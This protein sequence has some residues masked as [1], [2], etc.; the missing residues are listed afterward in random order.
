MNVQWLIHKVVVDNHVHPTFQHVVVVV[1]QIFVRQPRFHVKMVNP[2]WIHV[3]DHM[4]P[5]HKKIHRLVVAW[6]VLMRIQR[7][8]VF[9]VELFKPHFHFLV[10]HQHNVLKLVYK[11]M[12]DVIFLIL[13]PVVEMIVQVINRI[14][15]VN[16]E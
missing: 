1:V 8:H 14:A 11:P 4:V 16:V 6:I 3:F 15:A 12:L 13:K 7:V 2:V 9:V 5:V 10:V